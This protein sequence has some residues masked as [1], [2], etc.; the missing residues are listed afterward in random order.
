MKRMILVV[1]L[2]LTMV[3]VVD[4]QVADLVGPLSF[5][6]KSTDE[7]EV[8]DKGGHATRTLA[9]RSNQATGFISMFGVA[10]FPSIQLDLT[11]HDDGGDTTITVTCP[12]N[13]G[14]AVSARA[15]N[16]NAVANDQ[17][18]MQYSCHM[19]LVDS[20]GTTETDA[21]SLYLKGKIRR[22][23]GDL[24]EIISKITLSGCTLSGAGPENNAFV[25]K[26]TFSSVLQ[27]SRGIVHEKY[28]DTIWIGKGGSNPLTQGKKWKEPPNKT[29]QRTSS[30]PH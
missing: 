11:A 2:L 26:G 6:I 21:V 28:L 8:L 19:T 22:E 1:A 18:Q 4:A 30:R 7:T 5:K 3:G 16:T 13:M 17:L 27:Q 29:I 25:F 23:K 14:G 24:T 12:S 9:N 20:D 15:N 10:N